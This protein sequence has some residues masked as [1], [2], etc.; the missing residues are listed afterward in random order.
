MNCGQIRSLA[1]I[2]DKDVLLTGSI[3]GKI[4][5]YMNGKTKECNVCHSD[6]ELWGLAL[7]DGNMV[8]TAGDDNKLITYSPATGE[9]GLVETIC[10][11]DKSAP[12]KKPE[13]ASR[14]YNL[15]DSKCS[16]ALATC[17]DHLAVGH[18]DG[19]VVIRYK[20]GSFESIEEI[21]YTLK[22]ASDWI[23]VL[24]YSPDG[25]KLAVGSSDTNIY[26]YDTY[27]YKLMK[28]V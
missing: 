16:R 4:L 12:G 8:L 23:R 5:A 7:G 28:K 17:K 2:K 3:D 9:K 19:R 15:A 22:D 20:N 14:V 10:N 1:Y 11:E 13:E 27:G 18:N 26:I 21:L 24:S 6:G 25:Q